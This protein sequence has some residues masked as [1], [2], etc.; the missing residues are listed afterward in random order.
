MSC[1]EKMSRKRKFVAGTKKIA[2]KKNHRP[3][4]H[5]QRSLLS[6]KTEN[7]V[8][9]FT[10]PRGF[11][12][13]AV[14]P[15]LLKRA[16]AKIILPGKMSEEEKENRARAWEAVLNE[17]NLTPERRRHLTEVA[18]RISLYTTGDVLQDPEARRRQEQLELYV[19]EVSPGA[20]EGVFVDRP[21]G[22][23]F[24]RGKPTSVMPPDLPNAR[25]KCVLM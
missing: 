22:F 11:F 3:A 10:S 13:L 6:R 12:S 2:A 1:N 20:T 15:H 14:H 24:Y 17:M 23:D 5:F 16:V 21:N 9:G 7:C 25:D 4:V 19:N 8:T 18:S